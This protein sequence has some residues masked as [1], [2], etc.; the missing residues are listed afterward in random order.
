VLLGQTR[1]EVS[2]SEWAHVVHGHL[3]G[4][5]PMVDL[6]AEQRLAGVLAEAGRL[7]HLHCAHDLSEGGLGQALVEACLRWGDGAQVGLPDEPSPFVQLFSESTARVLAAVAP[8]Q[9]G[10]FLGLA[11]ER[12]VPAT[13][14]GTV[15]PKGSALEIAN[16]LM[17][18]LEELRS[19]YA[20]TLPAHFD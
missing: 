1:E 4:V 16:Q 12:G 13:V 17:I 20:A 6:A 2:G 7:G 3:G 18:S 10:A 9:E 15:G 19:A 8:G 5:P 14:L 11:A